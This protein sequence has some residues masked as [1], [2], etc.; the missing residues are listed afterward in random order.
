MPELEQDLR[1]TEESILGDADRL[2]NLEKA[3]SDLD[4]ADER[5]EDASVDVERVA[6]R[7]QDKAAAERE[8]AKRIQRSK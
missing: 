7:L 5:V 1:S 8:L 2:R 6:E 4:P 3:K